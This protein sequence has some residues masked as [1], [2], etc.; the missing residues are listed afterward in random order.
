MLT[1]KSINAA[2]QLNLDRIAV[3][4]GV[5]ANSALR[6]ELSSK[7]ESEGIEVVFPPLS[8]T[9]D[10]GAMIAA[11]GSYYLK[12]GISSPLSMNVYPNLG[13]GEVIPQ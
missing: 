10:N 3:G 4:G 7:G 1:A 13:I 5:S 8:L 6:A 12:R 11:V 9:T 2:K